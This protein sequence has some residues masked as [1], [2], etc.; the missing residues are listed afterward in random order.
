VIAEARREEI[1][2]LLMAS[3]AVTVGELQSRF[4]ISPMTVRRD[5][6]VLE[7][8]GSARRT[9]GGAVLPSVA[10]PEDS[11][12]KRLGVAAEAKQRLADAAFELLAEGETVFLD[13][14]S[15][16]YFLARRIA[17]GG[18]ALRVLTNSG[19][20]M[21]A[22][23]ASENEQVQLYAIGGMERRL[24]GS[25][26][27]PSSVRMVRD[28]FV[29]RVFLSVTGVARGKVLTDADSLE[30]AVKRAMIEQA[31]ESVLLMDGS[32]LNTHGGHTI[33]PL[34]TVSLV[35]ADGLDAAGVDALRALDVHVRT[36]SGRRH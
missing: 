9:H 2:T 10:T 27:G 28:H 17:S 32:K 12:A 22:L 14:S 7:Q 24:T 5:L 3:G 36:V 6:D 20:A 1:R 34:R 15:T 26:V 16:A 11:F 13:S 8:R 19:P 35:L 18:L 30:A 4:G 25:F 21:Q 31:S 29:D 23:M 33:A